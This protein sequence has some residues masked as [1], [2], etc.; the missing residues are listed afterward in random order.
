MKLHGTIPGII[1]ENATPLSIQLYSTRG[2]VQLVIAM[3]PDGAPPQIFAAIEFSH[4]DARSIMALIE[5]AMRR[6]RGE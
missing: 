5:T 1:K 3:T 6:A 4:N 2:I